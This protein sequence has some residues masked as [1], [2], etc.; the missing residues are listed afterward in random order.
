[1]IHPRLSSDAETLRA[2][3]NRTGGGQPGESQVV[4]RG[5]SFRCLLGNATGAKDHQWLRGNEPKLEFR[6]GMDGALKLHLGRGG[7]NDF[8]RPIPI[9]YGQGMS[10]AL[11]IPAS[12]IESFLMEKLSR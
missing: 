7:I 6:R 9:S 10:I 2:D 11:G 3:L 1:M 8:Q 12:A 4:A 5:P